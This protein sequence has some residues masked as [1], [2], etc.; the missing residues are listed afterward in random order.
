MNQ[1]Y[2][3]HH[4]LHFIGKKTQTPRGAYGRRL[5]IGVGDL[6]PM[7]GIPALKKETPQISLPASTLWVKTQQEGAGYEPGRSVSP[8]RGHAG[9]LLWDLLASRT[10]RK[11]FLRF[12]HYPMS[13]VLL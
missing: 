2:Y 4:Y 12:I 5:V 7:N 6:I 3:Y 11:Q 1:H 10:V 9:A 13:G 8:K